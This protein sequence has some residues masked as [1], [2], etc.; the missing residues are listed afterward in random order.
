MECGLFPAPPSIQTHLNNELGIPYI[1]FVSQFQVSTQKAPFL[2][3]V[4]HWCKQLDLGIYGHLLY[5]VKK[6]SSLLVKIQ[7]VVMLTMVIFRTN[8]QIGTNNMICFE[9]HCFFVLFQRVL[10]DPK[11]L[12]V[13]YTVDYIF[14][15]LT[16][17]N[18]RA[19]CK[20]LVCHKQ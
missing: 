20:A 19:W 2:Q 6:I 10:I 9:S 18:A 17:E 16:L 8:K 1:S 14:V 12:Y 3:K 7:L 13:V 5:L 15:I 11:S 4:S